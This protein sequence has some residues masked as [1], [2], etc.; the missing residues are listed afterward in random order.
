M[1]KRALLLALSA[2]GCGMSL[3][4]TPPDARPAALGASAGQALPQQRLR[5]KV[6]KIGLPGAQAQADRR[7]MPRS[8]VTNKAGRGVDAL[9]AGQGQGGQGTARQQSA[10]TL[11]G[12]NVTMPC[13]VCPAAAMRDEADYCVE[14]GWR[15]QVRC[16][17]EGKSADVRFQPCPA[18]ST[19]AAGHTSVISMELVWALIFLSAWTWLQQRRRLQQGAAGAAARKGVFAPVPM[20]PLDAA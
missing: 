18:M 10:R 9:A 8:E 16:A 4:Q 11:L 7:T 19:A 5:E 2:A 1:A 17:R 14:T 6:A 15:Q 20:T 3:S 13:H 12:C